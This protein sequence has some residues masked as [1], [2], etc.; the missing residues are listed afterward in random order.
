VVG[1]AWFRAV[2][3]AGL[4]FLALADTA[5]GAEL[6]MF[7]RAGCP[8]C[9][10]WD[11]KVGDVYAK[12][13]VGRKAPIRMID[14]DRDLMPAV[15]LARPVRYTPTFVLAEDGREIGRIEGFPGED[16]FWG[17]LDNLVRKLPS[18]S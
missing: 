8:W 13:D 5:F 9:R 2:A 4:A 15:A 18:E 14:L 12:T 7:R 6:L 3:A 1:R 10:T 11:E 17:L 16:F